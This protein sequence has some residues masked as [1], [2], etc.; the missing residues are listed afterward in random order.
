MNL[1]RVT[2]ENKETLIVNGD[3]INEV[4]KKLRDKGHG[5]VSY[6]EIQ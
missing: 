1:Y 2:V 3:S 4:I 6:T 5:L